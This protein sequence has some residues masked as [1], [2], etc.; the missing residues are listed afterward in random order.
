M[1]LQALS[2]NE[3]DRAR[4]TKGVLPDL[5]RN[6]RKARIKFAGAI[7]RL[8]GRSRRD[9]AGGAMMTIF[10][11]QQREAVGVTQRKEMGP[12]A[13]HFSDTAAD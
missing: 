10:D 3:L 11:Y 5:R 6:R 1:R 12:P 9:H 7:Q 2:E 4:N 13:A 8:C